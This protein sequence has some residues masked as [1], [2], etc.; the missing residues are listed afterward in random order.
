MSYNTIY[1]Y[2]LNIWYSWLSP[3]DLFSLIITSCYFHYT[4][5]N[6]N[7]RRMSVSVLHHLR[8]FIS[9]VFLIRPSHFSQIT[10]L[11]VNSNLI[12]L[13]RVPQ[14]TYVPICVTI[15]YSLWLSL[16]T[17]HNHVWICQH[18]PLSTPLPSKKGLVI[19][20]IQYPSS[21]YCSRSSDILIS[22]YSTH[23]K[24]PVP[25]LEITLSPYWFPLTFP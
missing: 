19:S 8:P 17:T 6:V 23:I 7:F 4:D 20:L 14:V 1:T 13:L 18:P 9:L 5:G 2:G 3:K 22:L 16:I 11:M 12:I 24:R 10:Q 25:R 21:S 15:L